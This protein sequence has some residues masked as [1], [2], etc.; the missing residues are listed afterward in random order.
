MQLQQIAYNAVLKRFKA[1]LR[2]VDA[3]YYSGIES[4]TEGLGMAL[5]EIVVMLYMVDILHYT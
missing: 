2:F 4:A 3:E 5:D 1:L